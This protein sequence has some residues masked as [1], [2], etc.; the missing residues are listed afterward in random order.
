MSPGTESKRSRRDPRETEQPPVGPPLPNWTKMLSPVHRTQSR[1][2]DVTG[3]PT[4]GGAAKA[5]AGANPKREPDPQPPPQA[6]EGPRP[7][8]GQ[9]D[10]GK[11]AGATMPAAGAGRFSSVL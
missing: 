1:P 9:K 6:E 4:R 3:R 8:G 5:D 2:G 11:G 10:G 7:P